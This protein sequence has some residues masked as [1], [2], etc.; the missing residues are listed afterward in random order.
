MAT[1]LGGHSY[2][3]LSE[4]TMIFYIDEAGDTGALPSP[5]E[6]DSQPVLVVGGIFVDSA[7]LF[8]LTREYMELKREYFPSTAASTSALPTWA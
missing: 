4:L 1:P 2:W 6:R 5:P 3:E 8:A 7:H